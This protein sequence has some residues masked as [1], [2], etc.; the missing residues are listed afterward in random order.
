MKYLFYFLFL[1]D[2]AVAVILS[3]FVGVIVG[4]ITGA[5]LLFINGITFYYIVKIK[6][7]SGQSE[8]KIKVIN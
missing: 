6:E 1:I 2:I 8:I 3:M 4:I 7:T 5:V